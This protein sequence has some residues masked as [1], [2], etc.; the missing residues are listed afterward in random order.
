[1][2][3]YP[4]KGFNDFPQ[5]SYEDTGIC[6]C[7]CVNGKEEIPLKDSA[8]II[9]PDTKYDSKSFYYFL[10]EACRQGQTLSDSAFRKNVFNWL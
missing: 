1:M 3:G 4:N 7:H 10:K 9:A 8:K 6:P 2:S 5:S